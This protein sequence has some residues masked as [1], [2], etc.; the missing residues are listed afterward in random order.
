M[1]SSLSIDAAKNVLY[2]NVLL[3]FSASLLKYTNGIINLNLIGAFYCKFV[4][5]GGGR[6]EFGY[7]GG[8][9]GGGGGYGGGSG[10]GGKLPFCKFYFYYLLI[11]SH[12]FLQIICF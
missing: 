5:S 11:F 8:S 7:G 2:I 9:G 10:Y 3:F 4:C 12:N 6:S 1:A